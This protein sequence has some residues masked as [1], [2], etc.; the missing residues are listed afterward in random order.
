[1]ARPMTWAAAT[2]LTVTGWAVAADNPVS[3]PPAPGTPA[4]NDLNRAKRDADRSANDAARSAGNGTP[5]E[6]VVSDADRSGTSPGASAATAPDDAAIRQAI[7]ALANVAVGRDH[8]DRLTQRLAQPDRD[9][10]RT[11]PTYDGGY[12]PA[13]DEAITK[14]DAAWRAKYGHAFTAAG[15]TAALTP[16]FADVRQGAAIVGDPKAA[17]VSGPARDA[18]AAVTLAAS[19]GLPKATVPLVRE[20]PDG[21]KLDVPDTVDAAALRQGL[22]DELSAAVAAQA[23]WPKDEADAYR[24][25]IH[26]VVL[27]TLGQPLPAGQ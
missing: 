11:K 14:L 25:V 15:A 18:M 7:G 10:I 20:Q 5:A 4:E 26:R 6:R 19:H 22:A 3:T 2:L 27:A 8:M 16:S 12:G 1:M 13:L 17:T 23:D 21:W 24:A 9:R